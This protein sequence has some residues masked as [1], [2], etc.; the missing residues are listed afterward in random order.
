M[1]NAIKSIEAV[2]ATIPLSLLEVWGG[3]GYLLGLVLMVCAF[4]GFTF[5]PAGRWGLGRA[6]QTWDAKAL[7]SVLLTFV[8]ILGAGYVGSFIV[9]VPG[10]QTFESLKDLV[11]FVCIVLFGYPALIIVPF[12]YGLS[13]LIEGVPPAFLLD[14]L[15]GYFINPACFW[16]AYQLIGKR[17]DFRRSRTW[18]RYLIF[19]LAF[20]SIEPVLWGYICADK[21]TPE[22]S[23]RN[24]TPALFFTTAITWIV[25]PLAMLVTLPLAR[26]VGLYWAE[27]PGHVRERLLGQTE[28]L[29]QAGTDAAPAGES[30]AGQGLPIRMFLATPF[31]VLVLAMVGATAY[32]TLLSAERSAN[33]LAAQ[34]HHDSSESIDL[35]LDDYLERSRHVDVARR[36]DDINRLLGQL[37][38]AEHGRAFIVDRAG[39]PIASSADPLQKAAF[40]GGN[41]RVMHHAVAALRR[42]IGDPAALTTAVQFQFD[43]VTAKPLSRETWLTQATPYRDRSGAGDWVLMTAMPAAYYLEGVRVGNSRSAMVFAAALVASLLMAAYLAMIV[44]APICRIAS[45]TGELMKGD[46]TQ[47]VPESRL[48]E[49]GALARSFNNMAGQLQKSFADLRSE[50]EMRKRRERELEESQARVRLSENRLQLATKAAHLGVW[51]WDV[52]KNDLVWDDAMYQQYGIDREAFGGAFEAWSKCLAPEDFER[53][54]AEVEA[55]LRDERE[56]ATEFGIRWPDGSVHYIKG[57]AQTIRD[58]DGRPLRMVGVNYDI[59]EQKRAAAEI[60]KLNTELEQRVVE[61]TAQLA[62]ANKELEA[63]SYSVSHDLKAPLR[64][65]DGYSQ[66]LEESAIECLDEDGRLFVRNI[67]QG[68]AQ[69]QALIDDLLA[70]A[71]MDRRNLVDDQLDLP[72]CVGAILNGYASDL[73]ARGVALR[74]AV[75][76][77]A[78]R[79]DRE[80]LAIVLRNLVDNA[81]KFS[82]DA[83]P[84][85]IEIAAHEADGKVVLSVRDN[86]IGFDMKFHERI[87]DIFSRL[88]RAEDYAGTGVGLALVRKAMQRMG[89]RVWAES[90]PGQGATFFLELKHG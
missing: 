11:V 17:P 85:T 37:P 62:A 75:P 9:L 58:T 24:I 25:A 41:D 14:W 90:A 3:F 65:I 21:F 72:A 12:A 39:T 80:G 32:V 87:F 86:G 76:A 51:D 35:Q 82:R 28:W 67:R 34:L 16:M 59:T 56:F 43:I 10:A 46:L 50:V 13:D 31:I 60:L 71:R 77:L 66:L 30:G 61:R 23:Y 57:I 45:A 44:A 70:Y 40:A 81:L 69:M 83:R 22:I 19:V 84:P 49:L 73:A 7:R 36:L 52:V 33:K 5:R 47:R 78:V 15:F 68:V 20:M 42:T 74:N 63:F 26:K 79:A 53:A 64:G 2:F 89:G 38:I 48:E 88:Q 8:L 27:I 6:Q 29:W 55:A 1:D 54:T 4:G 18:G